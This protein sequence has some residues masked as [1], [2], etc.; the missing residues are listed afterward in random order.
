[1]QKEL[2]SIPLTIQNTEGKASSYK[3]K[4]LTYWNWFTKRARKYSWVLVLYQSLMG[5]LLLYLTIFR[6]TPYL[7]YWV[8]GLL[9]FLFLSGGFYGWIVGR[10]TG[11]TH[12]KSGNVVFVM[13][14]QWKKF[15]PM[16]I[17]LL[18]IRGILMIIEWELDVDLTPVLR[19]LPSVIAGMLT[20][21]GIT[22]FTRYFLFKKNNP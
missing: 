8:V 5:L 14:S 3:S 4:L 11:I 2:D 20:T 16:M 6:I 13:G 12:S 9:S 15:L 1:M 17:I 10:H 18:S 22:L 19:V 21:R 7:E